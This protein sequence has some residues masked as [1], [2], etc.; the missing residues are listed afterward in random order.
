VSTVTLLHG[1]EDPHPVA[2]KL[3]LLLLL[4][5]F[6]EKA[7]IVDLPKNIS[8]SLNG[9]SWFIP[10]LGGKSSFEEMSNV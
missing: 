9:Y 4:I 7:S 10:I 6:L 8:K 5:C 3:L 1:D 2:A